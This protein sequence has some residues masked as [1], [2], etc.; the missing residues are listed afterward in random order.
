M[1]TIAHL[2]IFSR[3]FNNKSERQTFVEEGKISELKQ[4][5]DAMTL[6][7]V[8]LRE[9]VALTAQVFQESFG[10]TTDIARL[11]DILGESLE[12]VRATT[13]RNRIEEFGDVL[14]SLFAFSEEQDADPLVCI[15]RTLFKILE[16][17]EMYSARGDK[18][19]IV[20]YGGSFD[21][22]TRGHIAA[23]KAVLNSNIGIQ[24]VWFM[25]ANVYF[26]SKTL[27]SPALRAEMCQQLSRMDPRL[28]YFNYEIENGLFSETINTLLKLSQSYLAKTT[29]FY[30]MVSVETANTLANWP[31]AD[32]LIRVV[33]FITL[34]RPGYE[35]DLDNPW[36]LQKPH[37]YLHRAKGLIETSSSD[38]RRLY[39]ASDIKGAGDLVTDEVHEIIMRSHLYS[40]NI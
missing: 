40:A 25:P 16:H 18:P 32:E 26:G 12:L 1:S 2:R 10:T 4:R 38:V 30:F 37:R 3:K 6:T 29:R 27:T 13:R 31:R 34:P 36:F 14:A 39:R 8:S 23:A 20:I 15:Q 33:P 19:K 7:D 35:P 22:P 5:I 11:D 21:P 9:V 28:K 24:E 17:H